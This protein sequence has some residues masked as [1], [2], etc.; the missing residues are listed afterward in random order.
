MRF[1]RELKIANEWF[2]HGTLH[3]RNC[4]AS[5]LQS[6]DASTHMF[7]QFWFGGQREW[8]K[9]TRGVAACVGMM[10]LT[11]QK[12]HNAWWRRIRDDIRTVSKVSKEL[13]IPAYI[14]SLMLD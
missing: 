2:Q 10:K 3:A 12:R 4:S 9:L 1:F 7:Q 8:R 13:Q 11:D 6:I 14:E 5:H